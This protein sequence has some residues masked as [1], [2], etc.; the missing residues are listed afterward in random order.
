MKVGLLLPHFGRHATTSRL[1]DGVSEIERL[2]YDSV[3][4]RD[5]LVYQ[6]HSFEDADTTFVEAFTVLTAA[7][8]RSARLI[9]GTAT[10][11]PFRHPIHSA[12]LLTSLA[13]Y[14]G[15]ERLLIAWGMGNDP[16]EF[17]AAGSPGARRGARLEEHVA[18]V[19]QLL[20]GRTITHHGQH[21][22]F[23]EVRIQPPPGPLWFWY[24]GGSRRGMERT[25][26]HFDGLLASR[27]PRPM[28]RERINLVAELSAAAGRTPPEVGVVTL[29]S[30][31]D[32]VEQGLAAFDTERIRA[33]TER[34]FPGQRWEPGSGLDGVMVAGPPD[35]IA[36]ELIGFA[37]IGVSHLVVDLRA[38]FDEWEALIDGFARDVLPRLRR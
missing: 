32:T 21:Y 34:R 13:R 8:A 9:L 14:A 2:G 38:R 4:V 23:D 11:I 3:W 19:R 35:H 12:L 33:D 6:P 24:G 36:A 16:L 30:P 37:K 28:L 1:L 31:A 18:V 17:T 5:H 20:S 27:I 7:A 25:V 15:S 22:S 29:V 10:L 26:G